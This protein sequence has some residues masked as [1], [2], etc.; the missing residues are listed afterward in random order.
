MNLLDVMYLWVRQKKVVRAFTGNQ[1]GLLLCW[2]GDVMRDAVK[3]RGGS[4]GY[5]S[6][7]SG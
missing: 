5:F 6:N 4:W 1:C 2:A 7:Q 3:R